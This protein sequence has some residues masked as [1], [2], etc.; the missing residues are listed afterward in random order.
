MGVRVLETIAEPNMEYGSISKA[1][2]AN[3]VD[4]LLHAEAI[5]VVEAMPK[6]NPGKHNGKPVKVKYTIPMTM[7]LRN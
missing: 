2:V 1:K 3:K 5:R 7:C 6:W 4:E